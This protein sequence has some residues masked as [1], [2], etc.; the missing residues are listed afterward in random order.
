M[1]EVSI[2]EKVCLLG[3]IALVSCSV[4]ADVML[5]NRNFRLTIGDDA[6]GKSLLVKATGEEMLVA[7]EKI[8]FFSV[9]QA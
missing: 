9:T 8:P 5:E 6:S 7:D 2:M 3:T 1:I 4:F